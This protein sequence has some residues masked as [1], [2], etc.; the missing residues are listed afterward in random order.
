MRVVGISLYH[1]SSVAVVNNNQLECFYKEERLTRIK[2]DS[3]PYKSLAATKEFLQ[4]KHVDLVVIATA[5]NSYSSLDRH[6]TLAQFLTK[7]FHAPV[8]DISDRHHLQHAS[9]AFY[10]SGFDESLVVVVDRNGSFVH[11]E[12]AREAET[13]FLCSYPN[14]FTEIYKN[15]WAL[16]N[17]GYVQLENGPHIHC[18][19]SAGIVK[20]YESATSLIGQHPL[21]NGKTMGLAAYG[22]AG[23]YPSFFDGALAHDMYFS[24]QNKD[25]SDDLNKF[26]NRSLKEFTVDVVD[27]KNYKLYADYAYHVQQETQRAMLNIVENCVSRTN[28][29]NVCITGGYG[30][31]VVANAFLKKSLPDVNFYVEPLADDSGNSI[32]AAMHVCRNYTQSYEKYPLESTFF[33]G[34]PYDINIDGVT[35]DIDYIAEQ[36]YQGKTVAVYNGLAEAGPRA[37]GNRSILYNPKFKNGREKVNQIKRREWYRPF[38]AAVLSD[39]VSTYFEVADNPGKFMTESVQVRPEKKHELSSVTHVD[40]SCRIQVVENT[41]GYFYNLLCAFHKKSSIPVVLNTSFNL[42]GEPLVETPEDALNTFYKSNIDILWFPEV[43]KAIQR[44]T[45]K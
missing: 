41:D 28:V 23:E 4:E 3:M 38:A 9:L 11:N 42:A 29:K 39:Y 33:H 5:T 8:I 19:S 25:C 32:G 31:N 40:D 27:Q 18:T 30:L 12:G 20:V 43:K 13:V 34:R 36:I 26:E 17:A 16:H 37:L 15:Y 7:M 35:V 44:E 10:N 1:D 14:S 24:H 21:E 22:S 2:R 6:S 45:I